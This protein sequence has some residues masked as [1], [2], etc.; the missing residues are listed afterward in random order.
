V[1]VEVDGRILPGQDPEAFAAD[2]QRLVGPNVEVT[3]TSRGRG[4][5]ADPE[6]P[7]L[8]V[9]SETMNDLDPGARVV[10]YLVPGAT[11][12]RC[13]PGIKVYGFMPMR[14]NPEEFDLAH[15]HDE[16]ISVSNLG[17][18]TRALFEIVARFCAPRVR[19]R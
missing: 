1:T 14:D 5:E 6:S 4:I 8:R 12:A 13:L 11:D 10:P 7:L 15:A 16:R 18:A 19:R 2:V 17:F 3:L 9:I